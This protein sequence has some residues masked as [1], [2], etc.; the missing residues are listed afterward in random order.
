MK[1]IAPLSYRIRR[2]NT[3]I[4]AFALI[5]LLAFLAAMVGARMLDSMVLLHKH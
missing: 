1:T 3:A 2:R 4:K 5:S